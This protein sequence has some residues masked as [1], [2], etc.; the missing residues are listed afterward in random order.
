MNPPKPNRLVHSTAYIEYI[1]RLKPETRCVSNWEAQMRAATSPTASSASSQP[2][3]TILS[4]VP[5]SSLPAS[6]F[7]HLKTS[8]SVSQP[9]GADQPNGAQPNGQLNG[10]AG[11]KKRKPEKES[12]EPDSGKLDTKQIKTAL[13]ALRNQMLRDSLNL[14]RAIYSTPPSTTQS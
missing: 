1:N 9:N 14:S 8:S 3:S 7:D 13:W 11:S 6:W 12:E 2:S 4:N 5:A 10:T